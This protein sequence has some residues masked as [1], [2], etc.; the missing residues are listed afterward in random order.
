[1]QGIYKIT[2]PDGKCY[3]GQSINLK[4]RLSDYK[5]LRCK[6]QKAVYGALLKFGVN[7]IKIEIIEQFETTDDITDKLNKLEIKYIKEFNSIYPNGYNLNAGGDNHLFSDI[8][9]QR[10]C[11]TKFINLWK[12]DFEY[13]IKDLELVNTETGEKY[14][15]VV[16]Y[17]VKNPENLECFYDIAEGKGNIKWVR[18]DVPLLFGNYWPTC[19]ELTT[20][21]K[22]QEEALEISIKNNYS[23]KFIKNLKE[24]LLH[25]KLALERQLK[26]SE[27]RDFYY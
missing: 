24:D 3:I 10:L 15:N 13:Y 6:K 9:K 8:S 7:S 26:S 23:K 16:D 2:F 18:E 1:M 11:E 4:R 19:D 14:K 25:D 20:W 17:Y 21:I 22:F 5:H 12:D 27:E